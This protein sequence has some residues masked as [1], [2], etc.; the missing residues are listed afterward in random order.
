M[1]LRERPGG[2]MIAVCPDFQLGLAAA[3]NH[4]QDPGAD[5]RSAAGGVNHEFRFRCRVDGS[6]SVDLEQLFP[7]GAQF[8]ESAVR[9]RRLAIY[10][11]RSLDQSS[12][13]VR[14]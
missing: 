14:N 4:L 6:R 11:S 9:E 2:W 13:W 1:T 7:A 5:P 10:S 12:E 3:E 8:D